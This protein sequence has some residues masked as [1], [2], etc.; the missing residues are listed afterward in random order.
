MSVSLAW[1]LR[2]RVLENDSGGTVGIEMEK[3]HGA[4]SWGRI[5]KSEK[6]QEK[7]LKETETKDTRFELRMSRRERGLLRKKAKRAHM[8]ASDYVRKMLI[9]GDCNV[10]VIKTDSLDSIDLELTRQGTN[11]NQ[12]VKFLNTYGTKAYDAD[13]VARV[14]DHEY[15]IHEQL[16]SALISLRHEA[17]AH[18]VIIDTSVPEYDEEEW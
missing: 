5:P 14:L 7:R 12:L 17:E 1:K 15:E 3:G 18:H 6:S 4:E 13:E 11:L 9:H 8:S 2:I 10:T 16:R